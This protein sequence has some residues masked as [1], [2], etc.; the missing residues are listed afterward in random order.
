MQHHRH[1]QGSLQQIQDSRATATPVKPTQL[2][3]IRKLIEKEYGKSF[4]INYSQGYSLNDDNDFSMIIDAVR[5][6]HP[7]LTVP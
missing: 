3:D 4:K 6:Q 5:K 7:T 2:D 1:Y